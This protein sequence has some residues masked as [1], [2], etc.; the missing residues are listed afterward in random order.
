MR[1]PRIIVQGAAYHVCA[2]IN[3]Q[4]MILEN[5]QFKMM[6]LD[7]VAQAKKKYQFKFRNFCIMGN[8]VH[9][10]IQ[11]DNEI[12]IS[13]IM[14]WILSVFALRYNKMHNYKGHVWY[15][16]F[17]SKVIETVKQLI[18]TFLYIS[19]NPVRAKLVS[20][21]LEF[22]FSGLSFHKVNHMVYKDLLDKPDEKLIKIIDD[23]LNIFD[24]EKHTKVI[25]ECSFISKKITKKNL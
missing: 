24:R 9:L 1:K 8:H 23:F 21:P 6:F 17:K 15:D 3:R 22:P 14:Q 13:K 7:V 10:D 4:E 16:R 19:C 5:K 20:H 25:E 2:R 18:N 12:T 11:P